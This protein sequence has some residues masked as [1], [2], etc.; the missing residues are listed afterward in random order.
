MWSLAWTSAASLRKRVTALRAF[1][2]HRISHACVQQSSLYGL[3]L[4]GES[5]DQ[6]FPPRTGVCSARTDQLAAWEGACFKE[7]LNLRNH[8]GAATTS[9][10]SMSAA[11]GL[12]GSEQSDSNIHA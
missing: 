8:A 9:S 10:S 5:I 2:S 6:W 7:L 1:A 11:R 12:L 3:Q 4:T